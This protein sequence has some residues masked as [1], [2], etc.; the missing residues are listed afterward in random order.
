MNNINDPVVKCIIKLLTNSYKYNKIS[1]MGNEYL[2]N[3]D[4][5]KICVIIDDKNNY[6]C[7]NE[8]FSEYKRKKF[9]LLMLMK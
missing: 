6:I 9:R 8:I 5:V 7:I 3:C 1:N 4:D 2:L